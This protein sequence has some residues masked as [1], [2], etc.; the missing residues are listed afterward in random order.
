MRRHL[1]AASL[2]TATLALTALPTIAQAAPVTP[3]APVIQS[4]Q[5]VATT[6]ADSA[7]DGNLY[8]WI[9]INRGGGAPCVWGGDS[10]NWGRC[11]NQGSSM[12]NRGYDGTW[13]DVELFW[14]VNY[15]GAKICVWRGMYLS[16]M[17]EDF[18]PDR[19]SA[20]GGQTLN[21]NVSSHWWNNCR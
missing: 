8:V 4:S 11:R 10:P 3:T 9:D 15:G 7:P 18:Y 19:G 2:L 16:N 1:V 20:G 17:T 21:D 14:D 13:P 5:P 12:E 6:A